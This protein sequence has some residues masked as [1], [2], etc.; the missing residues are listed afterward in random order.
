MDGTSNPITVIHL[1]TLQH[2]ALGRDATEG[3]VVVVSGNFAKGS[4]PQNGRKDIKTNHPLTTSVSGTYTSR[5]SC[6][7]AMHGI[8]QG[9]E[10][11]QENEQK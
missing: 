3:V 11:K 2:P 6:T 9:V 7:A 10:L 4:Y 1:V 8:L 5:L